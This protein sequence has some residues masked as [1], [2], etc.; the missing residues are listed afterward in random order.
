MPHAT[1]LSVGA[2]ASKPALLA[3]A[4]LRAAAL[5]VGL[6]GVGLLA[7]GG[8]LAWLGGS[9][10]YLLCGAAYSAAAVL[11]WQRRRSAAW[12]P[13]AV[14]GATVAWSW[15]EV[16]PAF[17][18][19][20]PRLVI[21]A[22]VAMLALLLAPHLA[23]D[24]TRAWVRPAY[25]GAG[26]LCLALLGTLA[27]AFFPH[28]RILAPDPGAYRA[29]AP[30]R[31]PADW[32]HYARQADGKRFVPLDQISRAN[33]RD[34]DVAWTFRSGDTG[35]GE[36]Q[37]VPMQVG[38]TLYTCSRNDHV[39][40]LDADTGAVRWRFD[41]KAFSPVWQRCRGLGY[42]DNGAPVAA[43]APCA[44]RVILNTIDARLIALDASSGAPCTGFGVGGTVDL[45]QGMGEVKPGFYFQ[46][47]APTVARNLIVIGGWV[48][49]NQERGEP[50]GVVRAFHAHNGQL[51]WAWD[52]GNPALTGLPAAG[53]SY[54]RGTPN[55]WTTPSVDAKLGLIYLPLGNATPDY[56]GNGRSA[57][58][59]RYASS[60]VAL[61]LDSGR[62]RWHFQTVHHDLW[63]YD[64]AAQPLLFDIP[65]GRGASIPALLQSTKRG[66][67]FLLNRATGTPLS[68]VTERAV[69]RSGQAPSEWLAP[70]QP[71]SPGMPS[72]GAGRLSEAMMWGATMLDQL[73]CRVAFR[74]HRYDGDFT[75]PGL[76]SSIQ[77]PGNYGGLNWGGVSLDSASGYAFMNDIRLPVIVRLMPP[78]EAR[79]IIARST[80]VANR[81]GP[82]IQAGTP[83]GVT[84]LPFMS[85]LGIP[86]VQPPFGTISAVNLQT[87]KLAWQVAAG[88]VEDTGP[89]G[90]R[91]GL[92]MPVGMPTVGGTMAT[93]GG[94]VFFAGSQDFYLRAL[95]AADGRELWRARLPVGS[96]S[97]PMSYLS[98]ATGR[99]Y[100]VISAGGSSGS[101]SRGDY[102]IA[103]ALKKSR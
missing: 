6:L 88:T 99:Q 84:I 90:L 23:G 30:E 70:T 32:T 100:I 98:P 55:M 56:Y 19:L 46:T 21:P 64:V 2:G 71:Y 10:Y 9:W 29:G 66:Q 47:S 28:G 20:L 3:R 41:P 54:T 69:P 61:D 93:A 31:S 82:A 102:V 7:G 51:A 18:P 24:P 75:P 48:R 78:A 83:Y 97:T 86:C 36:D 4:A 67:L 52:L 59:E 89:L 40:A 16:G 43:A 73:W 17:W 72:I 65:D 27:A 79:R 101:T 53:Q 42:H 74:Q 80:G 37:N 58:A 13:L 26:V 85:P 95:D 60:V 87:R 33:V 1:A 77:Y 57:A 91:T 45:K 63:D 96:G 50:S 76:T 39:A 22:L 15:W 94:L 81:H 38:S 44:R 68:A 8:R 35:K 12:L 34:L 14:L 103:Y 62:E 92:R 5:A 49:D 11:L 25:G